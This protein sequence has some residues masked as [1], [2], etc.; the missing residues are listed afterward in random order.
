[1]KFHAKKNSKYVPE[2]MYNRGGIRKIENTVYPPSLCKNKTKKKKNFRLPSRITSGVQLRIIF[3][4]TNCAHV[5]NNT[6]YIPIIT[7]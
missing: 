6:V 5:V 7:L 2:Y 4:D 1:M 3:Y